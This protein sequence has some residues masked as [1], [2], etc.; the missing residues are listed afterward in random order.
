MNVRRVGLQTLDALTYAIV[1]TALLFAVSTAVSLLLGYGLVG[2]KHLLFFV[3]FAM[4]GYGAF[5]LQPVKPWKDDERSSDDTPRGVQQFALRLVPEGYRVH[6]RHR[7]STGTKLFVAS[8]FV[9]GTSAAM[10]F[11]FGVNA[12]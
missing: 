6:S 1:M 3:G 10:E 2:T 11:V 4:F 12:V 5:R 8:V 9:L 7:L